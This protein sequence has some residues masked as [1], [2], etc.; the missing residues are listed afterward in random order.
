MPLIKI[1]ILIDWTRTFVPGEKTKSPFWWGCMFVVL[2]QASWG[3]ACI[4]LLNM[5]CVP[6]NAIW[7]F[8][9]PS[10]CFPV[11]KVMLTSASVQVASDFMMVYIPQGIIWKLHMNWQKKAGVAMLFGDGII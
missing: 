7:E 1:A 8:Y 4:I 5:Q 10:K 2:I 6:H 9:V 3:T 11:P